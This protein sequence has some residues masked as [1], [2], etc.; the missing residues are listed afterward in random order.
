MLNQVYISSSVFHKKTGERSAMRYTLTSL[1]RPVA[2]GCC[3]R[4]CVGLD[5]IA[6]VAPS[7]T[8]MIGTC[9]AGSLFRVRTN[10]RPN[11]V[12]FLNTFDLK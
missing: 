7:M 10:Y 12:C 8:I 9:T 11:Y 2:R 1:C 4:W 5:N 6:S 3:R